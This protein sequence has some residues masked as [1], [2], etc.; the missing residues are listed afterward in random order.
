[1][2]VPIRYCTKCRSQ[3]EATRVAR[4]SF[5]CSEKCRKV[6]RIER[7]R[8]KATI[9]CRLC[10]RSLRPKTDRTTGQTLSDGVRREHNA[11]SRPQ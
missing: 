3:I 4:G 6:D 7:R 10:G 2:D 5:Y 8:W 1:M 11:N 9:S